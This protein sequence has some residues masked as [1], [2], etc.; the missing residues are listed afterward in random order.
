MSIFHTVL[1]S[2]LKYGILF[3]FGPTACTTLFLTSRASKVSTE[4]SDLILQVP[5]LGHGDS[6]LFFFNVY[7]NFSHPLNTVATKNFNRY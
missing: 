1:E 2:C 4:K 3:S 5:F 7:G 6:P